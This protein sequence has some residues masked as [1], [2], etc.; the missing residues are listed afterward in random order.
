MG[1]GWRVAFWRRS[2]DVTFT[3][4][5]FEAEVA[6]QAEDEPSVDAETKPPVD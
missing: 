5:Q 2:M 6:E 4:Y 1:A 3:D